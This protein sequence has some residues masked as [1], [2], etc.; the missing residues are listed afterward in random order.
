MIPR[1][2]TIALPPPNDAPQVDAAP[3]LLTADA[4]AKLLCV[5]RLTVFRW[6][7]AGRLP[8][9]VKIGRVV[10]WR[11]SEIETWIAQGCPNSRGP[12]RR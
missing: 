12:A 6:R 3:M 9:P 4:V 7:S 5:S 8:L 10:R 2:V 11:R 1:P